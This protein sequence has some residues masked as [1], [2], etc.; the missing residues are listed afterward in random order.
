MRARHD[1]AGAM[2]I[3]ASP[4]LMPRFHAHTLRSMPTNAIISTSARAAAFA[5]QQAHR[6]GDGISLRFTAPPLSP[7]AG[8][9]IL[10]LLLYLYY[11]AAA[12]K[13]CCCHECCCRRP[14]AMPLIR[15][16]HML[17]RV[18]RASRSDDDYR[19]RPRYGHSRQA[20]ARA[21]RWR[22][23]FALPRLL[24]IAFSP[25]SPRRLSPFQLLPRRSHQGVE[26]TILRAFHALARRLIVRRFFILSRHA[27]VITTISAPTRHLTRLPLGRHRRATP[28]P[29][30]ATPPPS[31][32]FIRR[33]RHAT[34][35]SGAVE[36]FYDDGRAQDVLLL[37]RYFHARAP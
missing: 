14:A 13:T 29:N 37:E 36:P 16:R 34:S 19:E 27:P 30:A 12:G 4:R 17:S 8:R 23:D 18:R 5:R 22:G 33:Q 21:A 28:A 11:A 2:L 1:D 7:K 15:P 6:A 26:I 32:P 31:R 10:L 20:L 9:D 35:P 25:I 24:L 3:F